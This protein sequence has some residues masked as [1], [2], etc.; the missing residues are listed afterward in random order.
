LIFR[1]FLNIIKEKVYKE[2]VSKK[3]EKSL[4]KPNKFASNTLTLHVKVL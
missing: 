1:A 2:I 4:K 3:L